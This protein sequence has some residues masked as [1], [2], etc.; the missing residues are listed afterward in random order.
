MKD[1]ISI[2]DPCWQLGFS[3]PVP[4]R[5]DSKIALIKRKSLWKFFK[6]GDSQAWGSLKDVSEFHLDT[7]LLPSLTLTIQKVLFS[8]PHALIPSKENSHPCRVLT[9]KKGNCQELHELYV[10][11]GDC[12]FFSLHKK[13]AW[14]LQ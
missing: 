1:Q 13:S 3:E 9:P 8:L 14:R 10:E 5:T 6:Q 2:C 12:F 4:L 11:F 7:T